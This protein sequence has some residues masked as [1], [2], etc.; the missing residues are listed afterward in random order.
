MQIV[1]KLGEICH[2]HLVAVVI[3]DVQRHRRDHRI[4]HGGLLFKQIFPRAGSRS[5]RMPAAPLIHRQPHPVLHP[6]PRDNGIMTADQLLRPLC[7]RHE[8]IPIRSREVK[9]A[10]R[11]PAVIVNAH[12][13]HRCP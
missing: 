13:V 11:L 7:A 1:A 5:L 12:P 8:L 3:E 4:P 2:P 6:V 10:P 9:R